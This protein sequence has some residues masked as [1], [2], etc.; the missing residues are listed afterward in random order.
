MEKNVKDH[1]MS[2]NN[3]IVMKSK[4]KCGGLT[5][6]WFGHRL[7]PVFSVHRTAASPEYD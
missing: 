4:V 6:F 2:C 1:L 5:V 3:I 7:V